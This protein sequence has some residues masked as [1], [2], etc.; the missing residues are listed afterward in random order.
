MDIVLFFS[1][2]NQLYAAMT[3]L[4]GRFCDSFTDPSEIFETSEKIEKCK[5]DNEPIYFRWNGHRSGLFCFSSAFLHSPCIHH[6]S[7]IDYTFVSLILC[8]LQWISYAAAWSPTLPR[9]WALRRRAV[10]V[11][12]WKLPAEISVAHF[13]SIWVFFFLLLLLGLSVSL[14]FQSMWT[15][16]DWS[17]PLHVRSFLLFEYLYYSSFLLVPSRGLTHSFA[18]SSGY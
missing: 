4:F 11:L 6:R 7:S 18:I 2:K 8:P 15:T 14:F 10:A 16:I 9:G 12:R 5:G 1:K 3:I 13:L 17:L